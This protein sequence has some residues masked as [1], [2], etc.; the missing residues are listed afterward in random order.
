[1]KRNILIVM[2]VISLV[3]V[4]G[5]ITASAASNPSGQPF[6]A[7]QN[8]IN[9]LRANY[10]NVTGDFVSKE[11]YN[12]K[13]ASLEGEISD[14]QATI[15]DLKTRLDALEAGTECTDEDT[16]AC[17]TNVGA[18]DMGTKTC[19]DGVW[20]ECLGATW[21]TAETCNNVDDNCDGTVDEGLTNVCGSSVGEC[22]LGFQTCSAGNW[23]TCMGSTE[24]TTETCDG[25]DNDCDGLVDEGLMTTYYRDADTDGYGNP[26]LPL[27]TCGDHTGYV[28]NDG[29]CND[30]DP[31]V[32]S[33]ATESCDGKDNNC[34]NVIDETFNVGTSC[35]AGV[36][37]CAASGSYVCK[38]D[39]SGTEC[40]AVQGTPTSETCND[41]DDDCDGTTDEGVC[42]TY[43]VDMDHDTH[44]SMTTTC[45]SPYTDCVTSH[46]DCHDADASIYPGATEVCDGKDN[47]C[48][49]ATVDGVDAAWHGTACDG[50]DTDACNEGTF[51]CV[52]GSQVCSDTTGNN[53]EVCDGT[54]NNCNGQTDEPANTICGTIANGN[55]LCSSGNCI[56]GS[57]DSGYIDWNTV[58]SD[59]CEFIKMSNG[60]A[61]TS[62]IQCA[63]GY[64]VNSLCSATP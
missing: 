47:D 10:N 16:D 19:A 42:T 58:F 13:V 15:I 38:S 3:L 1:M 26:G 27:T 17:G 12:A 23:G 51:S 18:C 6:E 34:N 44:G 32:Y 55:S 33:G 4:A 14:L 46:D 56:I 64:C 2:A 57:C 63:S 29:D 11:Q 59:G 24:P 7:L 48:N 9:A 45:S 52:S 53:V 30:A 41:I 60:H 37:A 35:S 50:A 22:K 54:D 31:T 62:G 28:S 25:K 8:Q 39:K 21:P 36:G 43:Y 49:S 5:V 61:C 40:N 20:G